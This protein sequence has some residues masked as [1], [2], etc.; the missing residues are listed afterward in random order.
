MADISGNIKIILSEQDRPM[1]WLASKAGIT[2]GGLSKM[3]D[4]NSFKSETLEAIANALEVPVSVL[5]GEEPA[6]E[7]EKNERALYQA[8]RL[9]AQGMAH[10]ADLANIFKKTKKEDFESIDEVE[11]YF[12]YLYETVTEI[13]NEQISGLAQIDPNYSSDRMINKHGS[14]QARELYNT[15][16]EAAEMEEQKPKKG[17]KS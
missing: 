10:L 16:K 17:A 14:V 12:A 6:K 1:T 2:P 3:L 9:T 15:V 5:F 8:V 11:K 13:I 7:A 4:A